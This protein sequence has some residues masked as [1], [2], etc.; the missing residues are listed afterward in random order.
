MLLDKG[1]GSEMSKSKTGFLR[2]NNGEN[3]AGLGLFWES[4]LHEKYRLAKFDFL[5]N[6]LKSKRKL[7]VEISHRLPVKEMILEITQAGIF[8]QYEQF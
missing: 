7:R 2:K 3:V 5:G 4:F 8:G 6:E 1:E